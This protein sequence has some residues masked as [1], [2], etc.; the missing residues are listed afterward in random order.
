MKTLTAKK[1]YRNAY[2]GAL[3]DV[4]DFRTVFEGTLHGYLTGNQTSL[5]I[6]Y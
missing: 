3:D 5:S 4:I 6:E 1:E 2:E